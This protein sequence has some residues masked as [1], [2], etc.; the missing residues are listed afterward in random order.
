M[1]HVSI[2]GHVYFLIFVRILRYFF[3]ACLVRINVNAYGHLV[4]VARLSLFLS[5]MIYI[6]IYILRKACALLALV[7]N[8]VAVPVLNLL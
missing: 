1:Y 3:L 8:L 6:Y 5:N 2:S 4:R 7:E